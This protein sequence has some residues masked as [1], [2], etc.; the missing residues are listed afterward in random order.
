MTLSRIIGTLLLWLTLA[1]A[2]VAGMAQSEAGSEAPPA[3][4][5]PD[6]LTPE[7]ID[8]L[9]SRLSDEQVRAL[10]I[11]RLDAVAAEQATEAPP[12]VGAAAFLVDVVKRT[13]ATV[14][15]RVRATPEAFVA[16]AEVIGDIATHLGSS[17]IWQFLSIFAIAIAA[18]LA[19]EWIVYR[20]MRR[21]RLPEASGPEPRDVF[22]ALPI[23]GR[24][25]VREFAGV[26]AFFIVGH[27]VI[28]ALMPPEDAALT[29]VVWRY[30]IV[31]P[32]LGNAILRF[33][34]APRRP[35][36]RLVNCDDA[37]AWR[38]FRNFFAIVMLLGVGFALFGLNQIRGNAETANQIGFAFNTAIFLLLG[39]TVWRARAGLTQMMLGRNLAEHT[40]SE[41]AV[42]R[43][44]PWY[45]L[46]VIALIY[47]M[48]IVLGAMGMGSMLRG[49][50]H[51][52]SLALLLI[53]PLLDSLIY[54][55]VARFVPPMRGEGA[56]A[57]RA[58]HA[59]LRAY[60]RMGRVALF[61]A[62]LLATARLWDVSLTSMASSGVGE[63]FAAHLIQ[64]TM[65]CVAGYFA[66]EIVRLLF[67]RRLAN[68]N[69]GTEAVTDTDGDAPHIGGNVG[70]RLGTVL[71]P[72]SWSVQAVIIILTVLT[73]LGNL[74]I[75][76]TPLLAGAGVAGLAIG[77]GAQK[78]VS[79][80]M[81]GMFFLI[82]DA[83]RLNEYI[84]TGG[85]QGTVEKIS[86]R[87]IQLRDSKGPVLII[88]YSGIDKVT[89]FG[90][91]WGIMKLRFTVPFGTDTE[92]VR[93]IFKK[94]GQEMM[95]NPE[96]APGFIEPFKGQGVAEF[97]DYGI[98]VR[99]KFM[100]KPGAQFG[101][102]KQ[103]FKRVQE[104]FAANGIEFARREVKVSVSG[105]DGAHLSDTQLQ[106]V[107]AAAAETVAQQDR[108]AAAAAAK[109]GAKP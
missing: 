36:L 34:L 59:N 23:L 41:I 14:Q 88:P 32:R 48:S 29:H 76:V 11:E 25:L 5:L 22:E 16:E 87:S 3:V 63:Q 98:V 1:L 107:S 47:L 40:P 84:D 85:V 101:I 75:N 19:A 83:F 44:Y 20:L 62:V 58:Y 35:D 17:G 50:V 26:I 6:P 65:I 54:A 79:D 42:A 24:R 7:A 49:G 51:F 91:D 99:G 21:A 66:W 38:L 73:A 13:S 69:T 9:V 30:L 90:R 102:R 10:L 80:I 56:L 109:A 70:S 95:E 46:G 43:W 37:T 52:V 96:L 28:K 74:G 60:V 106:Q 39:F 31:M 71:P 94:I 55:L 15:E 2:P 82:D 78:L 8:A 77:F 72:I 108:D 4:V 18:G 103:I 33:F 57:E 97:T 64:A 67:N 12:P 89:N 61:G 27:L 68:E 92:K 45:A 105:A 93:K 81:S 100:H 53:A 104:E 86:L